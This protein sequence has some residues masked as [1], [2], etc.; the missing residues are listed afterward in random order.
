MRRTLLLAALPAVLGAQTPEQLFQQRR[1]TEARTAAQARLAND[2]NDANALYWMGRLAAAENKNS[3]A[4]GWFEKAIKRDERNAIYHVWLGNVVGNEAQRANKLRQPFLARRVKSEFELAVQL[5]PKL[6]DARA[7]LVNFYSMAPGFMG[8]SMEKASEQ[9][10]AITKL[11]P[12][13]GHLAGAQVA[14]RQKDVSAAQREFEAAVTAAPDTAQAYYSL[15]AFY[16]RQSK[17]D[18]AFATYERLMQAR[19]RRKTWP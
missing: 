11:N 16:R 9:V 1:F 4:A 18:E 7:G 3:E 14:E 12:M 2:R 5:D 10:A 17:W 19:P 8:G 15:A 6:V 13:R